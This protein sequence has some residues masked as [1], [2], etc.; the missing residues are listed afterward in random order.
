MKS[1]FTL[2]I[3]NP[4]ILHS[5]FQ[6]NPTWDKLHKANS[7]LGPPAKVLL[8]LRRIP[9]K[10]ACAESEAKKNSTGKRGHVGLA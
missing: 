9:K 3:M 7:F 5:T 2:P 10:K 8:F 6:G 1:Y 4:P